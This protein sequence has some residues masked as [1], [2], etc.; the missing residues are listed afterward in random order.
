MTKDEL[1]ESLLNASEITDGQ[2]RALLGFFVLNVVKF[3][4][5]YGLSNNKLRKF[6]V[7]IADFI[8]LQDEQIKTAGK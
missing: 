4:F 1:I 2:D 6:L 5:T 8:E 3:Q 7:L